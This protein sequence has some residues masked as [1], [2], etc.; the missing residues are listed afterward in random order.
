MASDRLVD[1]ISDTATRPV[2]GMLEAMATAPLGDEQRGEDSTVRRLEERAAA[3]LGQPR[4]LFLPSATMA[5]QIALALHAGPG[6]EVLCHKTAHVVN[7]EAGGVAVIARAQL[8]PLEGAR[9]FFSADDVRAALRTDDPHH[10]ESRC[11]VVENTSNGG[12]GGVWPD[13]LFDG[14]ADLCAER[15]LALHIDGA[16]LLNAAV[17]AGVEPARWGRRATTVQM[18]FSKGLGCP[19]GAVL[20]L[21]EALWRPARRY[22]Q[23]LG[24]ALRQ[25]GVIAGAMLY[26]LDHHIE[27]LADDHERAARLAA[28][29]AQLEGIEVEPVETNLVYFRVHKERMGASELA[30]RLLEA[31]VRVGATGEQRLRACTHLDVSDAGI[32]R[33]LAAA[34]QIL[35]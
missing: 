31:G 6:D 21:P 14:V 10:P 27:R 16:R 24:G 3:L 20:A 5:N 13:A 32:A 1:L 30:A 19:F 29:L 25:A 9:G 12:G 17:R 26:A 34:R 35:A 8:L 4:A 22:K 7:Y 2:P 28:G 18:C 15:G 33:A 11:V 23:R